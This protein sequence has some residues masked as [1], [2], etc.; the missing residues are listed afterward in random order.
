MGETKRPL[1][2]FL[3]LFAEVKRGE[4]GPALL[5]TL[6][7][8]LIL[9]AYYIIKP[10][11]E[12]LIL[13]AEGGAELKA[14]AGAFQAGL[15][16]IIVP[17]YGR[18]AGAVS[19]RRLINAVNLFFMANLV[20]FWILA[21]GVPNLGLVFY[22]WVGIFNMMVPSLFWSFANDIYT[23]EQGKRLFAIVAFGASAGA[24]A[25]GVITRFLVEPL[26]VFQLLLL[27]AAILG[28]GL[29]ITNAVDRRAETET[30]PE[31]PLEVKVDTAG[32]GAFQLVAAS[33]Y[34]L[35]IAL[36]ML[37]LNWVNSNGEYLLGAKVGELALAEAESQGLTGAAA[38]TFKE[39]RLA[40]FYGGFYSW[41]NAIA[42]LMQAFLVSRIIKYIGVRSALLILPIISFAGYAL[43]T[44]VP[45]LSIIRISKI[46]ENSTDYSLQNTLRHALFLP[47]TKQEKYKAKQAIDTFFVRA[48]DALH[49]G[50]VYAGT[51]WW[52]FRTQDF[53]LVNLVLVAGWIFL[54]VL[55]GREY[56][57]K[58]EDPGVSVS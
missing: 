17:L 49:A 22:L 13:K 52:A 21:R 36:L 29:A 25:G 26:G 15:F 30:E 54:A 45:I 18:L 34:L 7:I 35:A 46:A 48:G 38:E 16:L 56:K 31:E 57:G 42:L 53:A 50:L 33:R 40:G 24:A 44:L 12:S 19:R 11:R 6:N 5:L 37:V 23:N 27:S 28:V 8:F 3:G 1:E 51:T 2:K 47:T 20:L 10:V 55:I 4:A 32:G 39:N 41:V 58:A 43:L 14:Y 9:T